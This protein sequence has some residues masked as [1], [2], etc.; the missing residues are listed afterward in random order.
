MSGDD[1]L[2]GERLSRVAVAYDRVAKAQRRID[3][4]KLGFGKD[5]VSGKLANEAAEMTDFHVREKYL[6]AMD[7]IT[8]WLVCHAH[9][10]ERMAAILEKEPEE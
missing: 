9:M 8:S 1:K 5:S 7:T 3:Q 10:L 4:A 2:I 6:N